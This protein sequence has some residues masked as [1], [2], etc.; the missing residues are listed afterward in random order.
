MHSKSPPKG[1]ADAQ[2]ESL[3]FRSIAFVFLVHCRRDGGGDQA[4]RPSAAPLRLVRIWLFCGRAGGNRL[5]NALRARVDC[6]VGFGV[7]TG[8]GSKVIMSP[9]SKVE[10]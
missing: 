6:S 4:R 5:V 1:K 2:N 8:C 9:L 10:M 3:P 7:F